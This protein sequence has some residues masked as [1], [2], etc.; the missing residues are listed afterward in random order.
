[1]PHGPIAD[2]LY[3]VNVLQDRTFLQNGIG[4]FDFVIG[5]RFD[6][7]MRSRRYVR[8]LV[9]H[10]AP[11]RRFGVPNEL[12]QYSLYR[13]AFFVAKRLPLAGE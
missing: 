1:M 3:E 10:Q 12:M 6:E 8:K 4:N 7:I 5:K 9:T 13:C 11:D 2:N